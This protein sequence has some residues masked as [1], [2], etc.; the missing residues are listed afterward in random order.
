[1]GRHQD[2]SS[3]RASMCPA[4]PPSKPT[5][6]EGTTLTG[7]SIAGP[8]A[9]G[10]GEARH[11]KAGPRGRPARQA[12]GHNYR[13]EPGARQ[14]RPPGAANPES[15]H[16]TKQRATPTQERGH[17]PTHTPHSPVTAKAGREQNPPPN[18]HT[19]QNLSQEWPG[20]GGA[21]TQTRMRGAAKTWAQSHTPTPHTL[22]KK[23]GI[24]AERARRHTQPNTSPRKRRDE[25]QYLNPDTRT[26]NPSQDWRGT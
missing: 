17:T 3:R 8:R 12:A 14:P 15:T 25:G 13:T 1:M 24:Q 10:P 11:T 2:H 16:S 19:P 5:V 18:K 7:T 4:Q 26:T 21:C 20:T 9:T 22:D 6:R 23:G